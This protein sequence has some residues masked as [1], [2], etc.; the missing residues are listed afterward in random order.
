MKDT[1][2]W[3]ITPCS[4]LKVSRRFGG[5]CRLHLQGRRISREINQ[6]ERRWQA[7]PTSA[8]LA[9]SFHAGFFLGL[10]FDPEDEG[11]MFLRND[12]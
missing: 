5:T 7:E 4:L 1:V 10:F 11:D 6:R 9:T 2:F 3:D 8:L 12:G